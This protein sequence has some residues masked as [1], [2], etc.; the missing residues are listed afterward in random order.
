MS[1]ILR[2]TETDNLLNFLN[3]TQEA[4][5][6]GCGCT[7]SNACMDEF[8]ETCYWL[9]VNRTTGSGVCSFCSDFLRHPLT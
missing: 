1:Q 9:K 7:D 6:V 3:F 8:H 5:C 4:T 2:K